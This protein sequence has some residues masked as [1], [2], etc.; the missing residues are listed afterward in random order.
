MSVFTDHEKE[1]YSRHLSLTGFGED[2]QI[3][4][5]QSRVLLVGAGG[6]GCPAGLY[7]AASG[8]GKIGVIDFDTV[9]R[10]NLQRQIAHSVHDLHRSKVDSLIDSMQSVN[11]WITYSGYRNK[12]AVDNIEQILPEYDLILDGSDNFSTRFL[13][14]DACYL[15]KKP[16]IQAAVFE[17]EGQLSFCLPGHGP[18]YRCLFESRPKGEA[19][20]N[21]SDIGVL[22]VLPGTMGL[23]MA[24]EAI[25]FITGWGETL[26]KKFIRYNALTSSMKTYH[27]V[28]NPDCPLCGNNPKIQNLNSYQQTMD[29]SFCG[30]SITLSIAQLLSMESLQPVFLDVRS[31]A[32]YER[33]HKPGAIHCPLDNLSQEKTK[34]LLSELPEKTIIITYCQKGLR[35]LQAAQMLKT[36]G[37]DR[38]FSLDGGLNQLSETEKSWFLDTAL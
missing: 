25:K 38:V 3:L 29:S 2:R 10:S 30:E 37:W 23:L 22:S 7:L 1:H 24:T 26:E 16:L 6:L 27:N 14:T 35:S 36:W 17:T 19:L 31:Q 5:K 12:L 11:P 21:C 8:V 13:L 33:L 34:K 20:P 28:N 18:C 4:L 9:E 32:E 15:M